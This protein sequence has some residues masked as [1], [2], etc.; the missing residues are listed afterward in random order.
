MAKRSVAMLAPVP[1]PAVSNRM[2]T[3][4]PP[5]RRRRFGHASR[6]LSRLRG[7]TQKRS[8]LPPWRVQRRTMN[9]R[10]AF[11]IIGHLVAARARKKSRRRQSPT[12]GELPVAAPVL[13]KP[14]PAGGTRPVGQTDGSRL[15]EARLGRDANHPAHSLCS[16]GSRCPRPVA[17]PRPTWYPP[18]VRVL[19]PPGSD[20]DCLHRP[21]STPPREAKRATLAKRSDLA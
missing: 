18:G 14:P 21:P 9:K 15:P 12:T 11:P 7:P 4:L 17:P 6:P 1:D 19:G 8:T 5:D 16:G 10:S 13:A 2:P 20:L 3:C